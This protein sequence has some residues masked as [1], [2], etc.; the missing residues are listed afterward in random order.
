VRGAEWRYRRHRYGSPSLGPAPCSRG[1]GSSAVLIV[2]TDNG[3]RHTCTS[4]L[5]TSRGG[6][7]SPRHGSPL[8]RISCLVTLPTGSR[9]DWFTSF[10]QPRK[11][12]LFVHLK[13]QRQKQLLWRTFGEDNDFRKCTRADHA[14]T[15]TS[16]ARA[17]T[18]DGHPRR[19][20]ISHT[21]L[22]LARRAELRR[23]RDG[24]RPMKM[25]ARRA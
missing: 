1:V 11:M 24:S 18:S 21:E 8:S 13:D 15:T 4:P 16:T 23:A 17:T 2:C 14:S 20:L 6:G 3:I 9:S 25:E 10:Q 22:E 12:S 7:P 19:W 5:A